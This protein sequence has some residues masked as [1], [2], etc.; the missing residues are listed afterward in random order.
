MFG[1]RRVGAAL[2]LSSPTS[3]TGATSIFKFYTLKAKCGCFQLGLLH[4]SCDI[5]ATESV[6]VFGG[7]LYLAAAIAQQ[8]KIK[9]KVCKLNCSTKAFKTDNLVSDC[10][11]WLAT[12]T[13]CQQPGTWLA[14]S[15]HCWIEENFCQS[16]SCQ[17]R[18]L[19][20][21]IHS[22]SNVQLPS[23][24]DWKITKKYQNIHAPC[25]PLQQQ[26]LLTTPDRSLCLFFFCG[27]FELLGAEAVFAFEPPTSFSFSFFP[28]KQ[29]MTE[30][31]EILQTNK[32]L[33]VSKMDE[34]DV[35]IDR[36]KVMITAA[37]LNHICFLPII[38]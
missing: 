27:L 8:A 34:Q 15:T 16:Q 3:T 11:T 26:P 31:P 2:S 24:S 19:L 22:S 1:G 33:K 32:R 35:W 20:S 6:H 4:S 23:S 30:P 21:L 38:Y 14:T 13:R 12:S 5:R 36:C 37:F 25:S 18:P 28:S 17:K 9:R 29:R 7:V 10:A